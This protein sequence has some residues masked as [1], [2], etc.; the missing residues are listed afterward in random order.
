MYKT[1]DNSL[2]E[3]SFWIQKGRNTKGYDNARIR[4][5][6]RS[7]DSLRNHHGAVFRARAPQYLKH[8]HG[9]AEGKIQVPKYVEQTGKLRYGFK[10]KNSRQKREISLGL[11]PMAKIPPLRNLHTF[12]LDL[13]E[14]SVLSI[15]EKKL[16][17]QK[18][19]H[20]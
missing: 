14:R 7:P 17:L 10:N 11:G 15:L 13:L 5:A 1:H 20:Q 8:Y 9:S 2:R 16:K 6:T 18:V 3:E 4:S 12:V 19:Q